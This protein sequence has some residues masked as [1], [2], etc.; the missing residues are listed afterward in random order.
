MLSQ[1][2][3]VF[4]HITQ[5]KHT[6]GSQ[7]HERLDNQDAHVMNEQ[8]PER[9]IVHG[10]ENEYVLADNRNQNIS[11][12]MDA[13]TLTAPCSLL[14]FLS[15]HCAHTH[16]PMVKSTKKPAPS[17]SKRHSHYLDKPNI[18][19]SVTRSAVKRLVRQAGVKRSASE[20]VAF[21]QNEMRLWLRD[22]LTDANEYRILRRKA[23]LKVS[24]VNQAL[25]RK[26]TPLLGLDDE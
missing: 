21:A 26:G 22:V 25:R 1:P 14:I 11:G 9:R 15:P 6:H 13:P 23:T 2:V 12:N 3:R 5:H 17:G 8:G 18:E 4:A 10:E 16:T 20:I 24:D 19:T 7:V